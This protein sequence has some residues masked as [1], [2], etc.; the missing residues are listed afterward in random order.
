MD[1]GK[2]EAA[3]NDTQPAEKYCTGCERTLPRSAFNRQARAR[4]GLQW[5]CREC[6]HA[7]GAERRKKNRDA[8]LERN[9]RWRAANPE[10]ARAATNR[11]YAGNAVNRRASS[12]RWRERNP[13][14]V[15]ATFASW[16]ETNA[17]HDR[18]R[19]RAYRLQ[20]PETPRENA[21]RRRARQAGNG[22]V[23]VFTR[24]EIGDRDNWVCGICGLTIDPALSWPDPQSQSL[25]HI[26]ALTRG[27]GHTR[28]NCRIAHL[29]CNMRKGNRQT[30]AALACR[31]PVTPSPIW[32][33]VFSYPEAE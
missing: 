14:K 7:A 10:R 6:E 19:N 15:K 1:D 13:E 25:D 28:A 12:Q 2:S 17:D 5:R 24:R 11:Q 26:I 30:P 18:A 27:G 23:E 3:E 4:D 20:N 33:G 21:R 22:E 9:R 29:V 16:R 8:E 32:L 31:I